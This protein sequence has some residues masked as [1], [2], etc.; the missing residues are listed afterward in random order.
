METHIGISRF[1]TLMLYLKNTEEIAKDLC[2][3]AP[4]EDGIERTQ[5]GKI[6]GRDSKLKE[7]G[8]ISYK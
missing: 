2:P 3:L 6:A 1:L 8:I 4:E 5:K 7:V